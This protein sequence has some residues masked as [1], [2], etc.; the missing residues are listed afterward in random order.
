MDWSTFFA[1]AGLAYQP[2]F[3]VWQPSAIEGAAALAAS[4]PISAWKDYLRFRELDRYADLLPQ[5]FAEAA[6]EF[7]TA[8]AEVTGGA[9][10]PVSRTERAEVTTLSTMS[11]EV[12]RAYAARHFPPAL[13]ARVDAI[14]ADVLKAFRHR[15]EQA[16]WMTLAT[17]TQALAKLDG[18][19]FG[20]GYPE[21]GPGAV[22][23]GAELEIDRTNAVGNLQ[24]LAA[25]SYSRALAR[26]GRPVDRSEW[27]IAPQTVGALLLFQQNAYN[28]PAA[29]LQ[30]P[31]FDPAASEATNYGAIGA[32]VGHEVSHFVDTLGA[33]YDVTGAQRAWWTPDDVAAYEA[34]TAPLVE[35]YSA[36]RPF[37]DVA[38]DGRRTLSENL[39]DLG[40][41]TA[42]FDAYRSS[43]SARGA[44]AQEL[45]RLDREFFIGFARSWRSELRPESL[46][47]QITG[48]DSHAPDALRIATVRNLD[49]WYAAFDVQP[50]DRL[51][52]APEKRVRVW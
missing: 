31:K 14:V 25:R 19:K 8:T 3:V 7:R 13:K 44:G 50:S 9:P 20:I 23:I 24:R 26:I 5:A 33:Q 49:A 12:G 32:I 1:G 28:F 35:Q 10:P 51:Y 41:L 39:A 45:R 38:V 22:E 52:L 4:E 6:R 30:P 46:R 27:W 47:E 40:G 11:E 37:P 48:K 42:A 29:L 17:R 18:V 34:A 15:V 16:S 2:A 43:A 21:R 36:Y